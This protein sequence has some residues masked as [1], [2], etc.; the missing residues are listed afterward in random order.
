MLMELEKQMKMVIL[1]IQR[2][3]HRVILKLQ[4]MKVLQRQE[5]QKREVEHS[6]L[7][8]QHLNLHPEEMMEAPVAEEEAEEEK[9]H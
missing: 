1:L 3:L 9:I 2:E 6:Q 4:K 5:R 7:K 8:S